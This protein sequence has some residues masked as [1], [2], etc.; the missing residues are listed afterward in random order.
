MGLYNVPL[1]GVLLGLRIGIISQS[2][3]I[4]DTWFW[5]RLMLHMCVKYG[6][7]FWPKRFKCL[8]FTPA[9][10]VEFFFSFCIACFVSCLEIGIFNFRSFFYYSAYDSIVHRRVFCCISEVFVA[11]LGFP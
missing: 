4:W 3:Q 6:I 9:G 11:A 1:C 2:F 7:A 8:M 10:P 5:L